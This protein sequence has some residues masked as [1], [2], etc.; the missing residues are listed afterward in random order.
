MSLA[1]SDVRELVSHPEYLERAS[2]LSLDDGSLLADLAI[3]KTECGEV[4]RAVVEVV[5]ARRGVAGKLPQWWVHHAL[6]SSDAAQQST[7]YAVAWLRAQRLAGHFGGG[8][9]ELNAVGV[10]DVTCSIGTEVAALMETGLDVVGSDLDEARVLMARHNVPGATFAVAD[11]LQPMAMPESLVGEDKRIIV[12]DPARR[13]SGRRL[14][15]P[16]DLLPP[17]PDLVSAWEGHDMAI[18]CA[19][20]LDFSEW[21]GE[22]AVTSVDG[23]V[24]EACLYTPRLALDGLTGGRARRSA[25]ILKDVSAD[26]VAASITRY[27]DTMD[28]DCGSG[29]AGRFIIDPD[30]AVVRAGLVRHFATKHG[31]WQL[32][33]RIAH[34]TGDALPAGVSGFEVL[35][36]VSLKQVRKALAARGCT[37]VEILVR[38][39]DVNPDVLRKQ[40]KLKSKGSSRNSQSSLAVVITRI[41]KTATAF[42]CDSRQ[43]G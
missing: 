28:D 37:S 21:D 24:K 33:E 6:L 25:W 23:G 41:G 2:E 36:Q 19:P 1:V 8:P 5:K 39:V 15:K 17:L 42:I 30:G 3:L 34:V 32:D 43:W 16:E 4:S 12:A 27:D 13:A 7:P 38:G 29:A 18:K 26:G 31:L 11:A 20:G 22:V 10:H 9:A 14:A 40:W 35:E